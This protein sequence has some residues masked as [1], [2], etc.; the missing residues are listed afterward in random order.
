MLGLSHQLR[1]LVVCHCFGENDS[2][3]EIIPARK[4][5]KK[6]IERYEEGSRES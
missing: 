5:I 6:E 1:V 3:M 4:A 2:I